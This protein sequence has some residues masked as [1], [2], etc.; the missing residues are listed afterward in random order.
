MLLQNKRICSGHPPFHPF[1]QEKKLKLETVRCDLLL[2]GNQS[3]YTMRQNIFMESSIIMKCVVILQFRNTIAPKNN[4]SV[5][6]V[7]SQ[8]DWRSAPKKI[9]KSNTVRCNFLHIWPFPL[10]KWTKR[11]IFISLRGI[12]HYNTMLAISK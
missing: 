2:S 11:H 7:K 9:L 10:V 4:V 3:K 6:I 1:P 12:G 8:E 5:K